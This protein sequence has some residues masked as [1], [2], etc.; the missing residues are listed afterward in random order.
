MMHGNEEVVAQTGISPSKSG[1]DARIIS[2]AASRSA[3]YGNG[4]TVRGL[5]A[6][7][8]LEYRASGLCFFRGIFQNRNRQAGR[9]RSPRPWQAP[10]SDVA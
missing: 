9:H 1:K 7:T 2:P 4:G 8:G 6:S 5:Y 10:S 3:Q